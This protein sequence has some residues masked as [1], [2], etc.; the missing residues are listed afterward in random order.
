MMMR[1]YGMDKSETEKTTVKGKAN[2]KGKCRGCGKE[3]V[4][5]KGLCKQCAE[6]TYA[7]RD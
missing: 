6:D 7:D 1:A 2:K 4:V 5:M 3:K